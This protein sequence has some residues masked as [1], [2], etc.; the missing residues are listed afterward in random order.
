MGS[1]ELAISDYHRAHILAPQNWEIRTRIALVH[2]SLGIQ[3]FNELDMVGA[4]CEL[5]RAIGYNNKVAHFYLSRG[6][7]SYYMNDWA[8]A[9]L[10]FFKVLKLDANDVEAK[11]Y[12]MRFKSMIIDE[13][14]D[15]AMTNLVDCPANS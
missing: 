1:L 7:A 10:D 8:E 6:R 15:K 9:Y 5:S 2:Y 12:L 3:A 13:K 11:S 14:G 4:R